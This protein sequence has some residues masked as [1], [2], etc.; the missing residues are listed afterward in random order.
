MNTLLIGFALL[1]VNLVWTIDILKHSHPEISS[2]DRLLLNAIG[3]ILLYGAAALLHYV[4]KR[5]K[6]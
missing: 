1:I 5:M 4:F 6:R 2:T 3:S